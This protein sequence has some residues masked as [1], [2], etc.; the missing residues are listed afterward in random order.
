MFQKD[1]VFVTTG[2]IPLIA[3]FL[4]IE[5]PTARTIPVIRYNEI[6]LYS[7]PRAFLFSYFPRIAKPIVPSAISAVT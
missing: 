4:S 6:A 3:L 1:I 2:T 7:L 5:G